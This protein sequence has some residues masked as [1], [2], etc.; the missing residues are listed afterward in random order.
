MGSYTYFLGVQLPLRKDDHCSIA[1]IVL[2]ILQIKLIFIFISIR[3]VLC[4]VDGIIS[5]TFQV[6]KLR[7][8]DIK[9]LVG[10]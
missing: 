5:I 8:R 2:S 4:N 10:E 9:V 6:G 1:G 3:K 7:F